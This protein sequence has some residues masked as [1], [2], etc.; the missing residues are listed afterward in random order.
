VTPP[1]LPGGKP[2]SSPPPGRKFQQRTDMPRGPWCAA[3][4]G[5][6]GRHLSGRQRADRQARRGFDRTPPQ[7][8]RRGRASRQVRTQWAQQG[9]NL[10]PLAY[11]A[12]YYG[13]W[14]WLDVAR[15]GICQ[16][17]LWLDV[18]W[19]GLMPVDAGSPFGS[20][21]SLAPLIF[22][23]PD[24]GLKLATAPVV[25]AGARSTAV[26]PMSR[27]EGSGVSTPS[28]GSRAERF[29]SGGIAVAGRAATVAA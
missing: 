12:S 29:T 28:R 3:A 19:R 22:D 15:C 10:R 26:C 6:G 20:P 17:R 16:P 2:G 25:M 27:H 18:A 21:I 7:R 5:E 4:R 9:S 11:K 14:T 24:G 13:R 23:N 1:H 8:A